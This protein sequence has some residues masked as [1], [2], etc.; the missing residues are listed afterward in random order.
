MHLFGTFNSRY[1]IEFPNKNMHFYHL[2]GFTGLVLEYFYL[3]VYRWISGAF[4]DWDPHMGWWWSPGQN[5]RAIGRETKKMRFFTKLVTGRCTRPV[6]FHPGACWPSFSLWPFHT[7]RVDFALACTRPVCRYLG[8]FWG[9][10]QECLNTKLGRFFTILTARDKKWAIF[11]GFWRD[12]WRAITR[13]HLEIL[14]RL[15]YKTISL[16]FCWFDSHS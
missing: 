14:I 7:P 9:L 8:C 5:F 15:I 12:S 1:S 4:E 2:F 10:F 13:D 11:R 6:W 3:H 16:L